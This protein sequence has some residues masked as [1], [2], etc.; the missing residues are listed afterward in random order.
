MMSYSYTLFDCYTLA[1]LMPRIFQTLVDKPDVELEKRVDISNPSCPL[2]DTF[3]A[4]D[5]E[6]RFADDNAL[7]GIEKTHFPSVD[8]QLSRCTRPRRDFEPNHTVARE[9]DWSEAE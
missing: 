4:W 3:D 9:D 1:G 2:P 8:R 5:W 7:V 6:R